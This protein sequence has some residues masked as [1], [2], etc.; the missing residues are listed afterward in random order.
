METGRA[1]IFA[2]VREPFVEQE[3]PLPEVEPDGILVRLTVS[4]ICGSDLHG[5]HGPRR[6]VA[7]PLWGTR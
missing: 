2:G 3:F 1:F 7:R 4:N 6:A 5:W